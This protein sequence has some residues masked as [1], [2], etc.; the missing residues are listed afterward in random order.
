MKFLATSKTKSTLLARREKTNANYYYCEVEYLESSGTQY[1]DTGLN[2]KDGYLYKTTIEPLSD[3]AWVLWFGRQETTNGSQ[4]EFVGYNGDTQLGASVIQPG[5]GNT[6]GKQNAP[7]NTK[8]NIEVSSVTGDVYFSVNGTKTT[9][10]R[11]GDKCQKNIYIFCINNAGTANNFISMRLHYFQMYD[12]NGTLVRDLIPVLDWNMVPC[13]FDKISK[14]L[15]YNKGTGNFVAGRQIHPIEYLESTGTQWIDSGFTVSNT[16]TIICNYMLTNSVFA[17]QSV[18]GSRKRN[19]QDAIQHGQYQNDGWYVV[20]TSEGFVTGATRLQK[21]YV[22]Y[23]KGKI[24]FGDTEKTATLVADKSS[25]VYT[26]PH[27]LVFFAEYNEQQGGIFLPATVRIY[28]F[29]VLDS[30]DNLLRDFKPAIDENGVGF[31]LDQVNHQ[32]YDNAGTGSFKYPDVRLEYL[33]SSGTQYIDTGMYFDNSDFE[34]TCDFVPVV[35]GSSGASLCGCEIPGHWGLNW[36]GHHWMIG[37]TNWSSTPDVPTQGVR[38]VWKMTG[39]DGYATLKKDGVDVWTRPYNSYLVEHNWYL[40]ADNANG[41]T[42][43]YGKI[44]LYSLSVKFANNL[45]RDFIPVLHNGTAC[46]Y[47]NVSQTYF[48]NQGTGSFTGKISVEKEYSYFLLYL[49]ENQA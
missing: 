6:I 43:Q 46:M 25:Q 42:N 28:D 48:T 41:V 22:A 26:T 47:D 4:C 36:N 19:V 38:L 45:V 37:T 29:K 2:S 11:S 1:I 33:E 14:K 35:S 8:Y 7:I 3:G 12:N 15:F 9:A 30:N 17:Q 24:Y 39:K 5:V 20:G 34:F 31:M 13:L 23:N 49:N 27:S 16:N 32:A 21:H 44:R 18:F 40:F 10:S